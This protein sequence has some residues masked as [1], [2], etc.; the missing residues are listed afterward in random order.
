M[1]RA[2]P[3]G[4]V[5]AALL[6][7]CSASMGY[8]ENGRTRFQMA[9]AAARQILRGL[10]S[11]DRVCLILMGLPQS[12]ADLEPTGDLRAIETRIDEAQIGYSRANLQESLIRAA[13]V[14]E[15]YEKSNRDVYVVCDRQALSW[16]EIDERF[17]ADWRRRL[18]L[19]EASRRPSSVRRGCSSFRWAGPDADN[20]SIE[21]IR[22]AA[23]PAIHYRRADGTR[24]AG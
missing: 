17:A 7:D 23:G 6:L 9:Q 10:Q 15:R 21:S 13:D 12:E 20:V 2:V 1:A 14:L 16:K 24:R 3:G 19:A 22:L 5:T 18:S 8:D 11:G 4:R